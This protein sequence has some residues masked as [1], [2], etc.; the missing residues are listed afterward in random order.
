MKLKSHG[1][2]IS[3][4]NVLNISE[5]GIW[6]HVNA[7]EHFLP[8]AEFPWFK[9]ATIGEIQDARLIHTNHLY[10]PK[11]DVDLEVESLDSLEKYSLVYH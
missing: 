2:G 5:H 8:Y 6:L 3:R 1:R 7:Q 9:K 10:W 11:L 4:V